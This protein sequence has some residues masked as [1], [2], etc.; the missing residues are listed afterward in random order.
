[1]GASIPLIVELHAEDAAI[2]WLQR[3]R[4]VNA[5]HFNRMFLG[6]LDERLEANLDG[7]RVAGDA[8]WGEALRA[9]EAHPE[10]GET[11]VLSSLAFGRGRREIETV[12]VALASDPA[13]A[14][15][16]PAISALGWLPPRELSG[17]VQ[18]LLDDPR[19]IARLLGLGACSAHRVDPKGQLAR[20]LDDAG[21][22][23]ARALRLAGEL[24]RADL[25][26]EVQRHLE[27]EDD[28][29][30]FWAEWSAALLGDRQRA[31]GALRAS[32]ARAGDHRLRAFDLATRLGTLDA[33]R[34]WLQ[35]VRADPRCPEFQVRAAGILGEVSLL[36]FLIGQMKDP[37]RAPLAGES[38]AMITG[39][40]IGFAD[41]DGEPP[42]GFPAGPN[43]DPA[44]PKTELGAD[45]ELPWPD[46]AAVAAWYAAEADRMPQAPRLFLG[47]PWG[48]ESFRAGLE[49]GF[50]RQR[51][52]AA[53]NLALASPTA[54][55]ANWRT[56]IAIGWA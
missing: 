48:E 8:G 16:R 34:A 29:C 31:P 19:P 24:G 30:R 46:A 41:L 9:F 44:D 27:D 45:D 52:A 51:R 23:R 26:P 47:S 6:R 25:L 28:G 33:A 10:P 11:F 32:A 18:P 37:A 13:G 43:D 55:L 5:P 42:E 53:F 22:V 56:R 4:A 15:V 49:R 21:P 2:Q 1:M 50:Q 35:D 12:L 36:P 14:L 40:D 54:R 17:K 20:F 3:D 39:V 38:F 7:L